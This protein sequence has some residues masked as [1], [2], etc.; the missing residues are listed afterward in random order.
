MQ[1]F[2]GDS[3]LAAA[4]TPVG[5]SDILVGDAPAGARY[6]VDSQ[7]V[8]PLNRWARGA[9]AEPEDLSA[10][11]KVVAAQVAARLAADTD[12]AEVPA[13]VLVLSLAAMGVSLAVAGGLLVLQ[14]RR[15]RESGTLDP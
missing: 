10:V 5:P 7:T 2:G 15:T 8:R 11:Q 4:L 13:P 9:V 14:R 6:A 3:D 1:G 12:V